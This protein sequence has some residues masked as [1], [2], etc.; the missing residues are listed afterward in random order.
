[1]QILRNK[2]L[3]LLSLLAFFSAICDALFAQDSA[4]NVADSL[5]TIGKYSQAE[6]IYEKN[7]KNS[8]K[9][10]PNVLIKLSFLAEKANDPG[11]TLYYL[12]LL[13]QI[14]PTISLFEKMN[15][16]AE[17]NQLD[18]YIFNDLSYFMVFYRRYGGYIPIL[19][20]SLGLYV[21]VVM[22]IK[23]RSGEWIQ[24]RHKIAVFMYLIALLGL[25]NIP[26]NY[27]TGVVK[28]ER[29]FMRGFPSSAAPVVEVIQKGNKLTII[30]NRDR[31]KRVIWDGE[32]GYIRENDLWAL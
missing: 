13:S 15:Q 4:L 9:Y 19:L 24:R 30:G 27:T 8:E 31:W 14:K 7:F 21:V 18:G 3:V 11:K 5:F 16:I 2:Y 22:V 10:N 23:V 12:S 32:I 29:T 25:L 1:M 28:T 17:M 20:L 6:K 26:A